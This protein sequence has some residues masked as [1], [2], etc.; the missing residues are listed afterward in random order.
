METP[1]L[2][3]ISIKAW[4]IYLLNVGNQTIQLPSG[5][6]ITLVISGEETGLFQVLTGNVNSTV[7]TGLYQ[8]YY[9]PDTLY[10]FEKPNPG[11]FGPAGIRRTTLEHVLGRYAEEK[12]VTNPS[13]GAYWEASKVLLHNS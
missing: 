10:I 3:S 8:A 12:K 6:V 1:Y 11:F 7:R 2:A 5:F 13:W 9:N 4:I